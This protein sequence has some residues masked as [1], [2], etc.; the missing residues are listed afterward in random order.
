ALTREGEL[1][2]T[3]GEHGSAPGQLDRP[4][5]IA[6][7]AD[8]NVYV[9]DTLNHRV[10]LFTKGGE[11][12]KVWGSHGDGPGELNMPWGITVDELGDVYVADWRNDRVQKFN[13]NGELLLGFGESGSDDGQL[14]RP[15]GVDVDADG[16]IYVADWGNDR[17]QL[18][19]AEGRYVEKFIGDATMSRSGRE[20]VLANPLTLRLRE[21]S[22][23][24]PQKRLRGPMSVRVDDDGRMYIPDYGSHRIQV[25]KKE[26]YPLE[27]AQ[28]AAPL[29][30]PT[31]E[32]A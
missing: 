32:T 12:I 1:L 21:D 5:G 15:S 16:D 31:L 10:Q 4:S 23:L 9:S 18:F 14:N 22:R 3:W 8:E 28:I 17:V 13:N 30:S 19:N 25:Y 27:P 24:E 26:A 20:Y 11:F 7:D 29:R 2:S 6:F